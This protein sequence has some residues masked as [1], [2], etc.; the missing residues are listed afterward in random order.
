VRG[1]IVF[2]LVI[3]VG[4]GWIVRQAHIQRDAVAAIRK[5]GGSVFYSWEWDHGKAIPGGRPRQP[6][7]VV[8]SIGVEVYGQV[9]GVELW[10]SYGPADIVLAAAGRLD[11][12]Q[13]LWVF[14]HTSA[15][16]AGLMHLAGLTDLSSLGLNRTQVTDAGL[17]HLKGLAKLSTLVLN[18]TQVTDAG[19]VHLK[20]LTNLS[21]LRLDGTQ[22]TDAGLV[23]L[24]RLTKLSDLWLNGT[25]VTDVGL[26][27]LKGLTNLSY[28]RLDG[29]RV[30]DAGVD[31]LKRSLPRLKISR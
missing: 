11:R 27:H 19:L 10:G 17:V 24:G 7:W 9:T 5:A 31:E 23:H 28:L 20:G 25:Q 21:Y 3:G 16:D 8:E 26:V 13:R 4:L 6:S 12:L 15:T 1:L 14:T 22:V 30:T 2:V 18:G 29:T